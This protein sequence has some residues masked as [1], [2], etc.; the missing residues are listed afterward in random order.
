MDNTEIKKLT[1]QDYKNYLEQGI[2]YAEYFGNAEKEATIEPK[3]GYLAYVPQNVQ[4]MKRIGKTLQLSESIK[5]LVKSLE[6]DINWLIISEHWCGDAA[7]ILPIFDAIARFSEGKINLKIVYRD[8]NLALMDAHLTGQSRSIPKLIQLDNHF[9]IIGIWGPRPA[10]AQKM[11]LELKQNI[12]TAPKYADILHKWY[13]D[14]KQQTTQ[15][16]ILTLLQKGSQF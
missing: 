5:Q 7:Q 3:E 12:E 2:T 8:K 13:A 6:N 10:V 1:K 15:Q 16:E 14:D 9:N 11:V 4:R